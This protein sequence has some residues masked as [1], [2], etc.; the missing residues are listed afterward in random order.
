MQGGQKGRAQLRTYVGKKDEVLG[1]RKEKN[2][3][4][5]ERTHGTERVGRAGNVCDDDKMEK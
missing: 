3:E 4:R 2:P 1:R 5:N